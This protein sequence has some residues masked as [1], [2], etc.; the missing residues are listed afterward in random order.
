MDNYFLITGMFRSGTTLISKMLHAHKEISCIPDAYSPFFNGFRDCIAGAG[1]P[2]RKIPPL[3]YLGDYFADDRDVELYEAIQSAPFDQ[4]FP[5]E[6]KMSVTSAIKHRGRMTSP[7]VISILD[8]I[9]AKTFQGAYKELISLIRQAYGT[10]KE[11]WTGNKEVWISEFAPHILNAFPNSKI[12]L[13]NRDPRAVLASKNV[14]SLNAAP[15]IRQEKYPWLFL[16]RQWRK[17]AIINWMLT[18]NALLKDR[19]LS[20]RY[21]DVVREPEKYARKISSFLNLPFDRNM[22]HPEK[23]TDGQGDVW[24]QNSSYNTINKKDGFL[25]FKKTKPRFDSSRINKWETALTEKQ[26]RYVEQL[27]YTEMKLHGYK[28]KLS[29]SLHLGD[30]LIFNPPYAKVKELQ[31]WIQKEYCDEQWSDVVKEMG[32]E[33]IRHR[34]LTSGALK[35]DI[36]TPKLIKAYFINENYFI[37]ARQLVGKDGDEK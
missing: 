37:K 29:S 27:C 17:I 32:V 25:Q 30:E 1:F 15:G 24:V 7:K 31:E 18:E 9:K 13:V 28:P 2:L 23:F 34:M 36:Y 8:Q 11:I 26:I 19:I 33:A 4:P 35:E 3:Q 22:I 6:I 16:I 12:I 21:E 20:L 5:K 14:G 10:G